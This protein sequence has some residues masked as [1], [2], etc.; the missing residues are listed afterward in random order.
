MNPEQNEDYVLVHK[1]K[2]KISR[3]RKLV[4]GTMLVGAV[5]AI[6]GA[7]TFASFSASTTNNATFTTARMAIS[8]NTTCVTPAGV[9]G[10]GVA[11]PNVDANN[12]TCAPLFPTPLKPGVLATKDVEIQNVG[13]V[14]GALKLYALANCAV[15]VNNSGFDMGTAQ[16]L[17]DRVQVSFHNDTTNNCIY[18]VAVGACVAI[19]DSTTGQSFNDFSSAHKFN[20]PLSVLPS[21]GTDL[22]TIGVT[23][24]AKVT[25]SVYWKKTTGTTDCSAAL[26]INTPGITATDDTPTDGFIDSNGQGC[27]N[28][29]MNQKASLNLR[30][31]IQG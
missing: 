8:N 27:D 5:A 3:A 26:Q 7:G 2:A 28:P 24:K 11:S 17:C 21:S 23:N 16:D 9:A 14:D 6:A 13:D 30:W 4:I 31:Q 29:Y 12:A 19:T 1:T 10:T 25:V 18:P 15:T 22:T 20:A